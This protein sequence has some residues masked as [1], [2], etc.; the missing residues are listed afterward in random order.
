MN[1]HTINW[2]DLA[3][4]T[5][6]RVVKQESHAEI[7]A[8]LYYG[9]EAELEEGD[10]DLPPKDIERLAQGLFD[11]VLMMY[12]T[13]NIANLN[14]LLVLA[15]PP[16]RNPIWTLVCQCWMKNVLTRVEAENRPVPTPKVKSHFVFFAAVAPTM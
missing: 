8:D 6:H 2:T 14:K 4:D 15:V 10:L 12:G 5:V 13:L 1:S 11:C 7:L 16:G 9:I 3:T